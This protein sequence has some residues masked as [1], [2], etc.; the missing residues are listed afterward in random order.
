MRCAEDRVGF[1]TGNFSKKFILAV[2]RSHE[3][4]RDI[5]TR[6]SQR[7]QYC[8]SSSK[9][10]QLHYS[11]NMPNHF[12]HS[13]FRL[14]LQT[15]RGSR[16][17]TQNMKLK[18]KYYS[19]PIILGYFT[20]ICVAHPDLS[21]LPS[22]FKESVV[23]SELVKVNYKLNLPEAQMSRNHRLSRSEGCSGFE[24]NQ[25]KRERNREG[26]SH[27]NPRIGSQSRTLSVNRV[28]AAIR[29]LPQN[30]GD[31]SSAQRDVN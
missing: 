1:Q 20:V 3:Q 22:S 31:G 15:T 7:R 26:L 5:F 4:T 21:G 25:K 12:V 9:E 17:Y 24:V 27:P 23:V 28:N 14:P 2:L 10:C 19:F 30:E 11:P 16:S 13:D 18:L 29:A 8:K 6:R